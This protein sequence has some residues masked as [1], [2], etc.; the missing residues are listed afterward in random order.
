MK[1]NG[2]YEPNLFY[3]FLTKYHGSFNQ[4]SLTNYLLATVKTLGTNE[5]DE[6]HESLLILS[7]LSLWQIGTEPS[8]NQYLVVDIGLGA[9]PI[10]MI[11]N[12]GPH[13]TLVKQK[14]S[15]NLLSFIPIF[16]I[17]TFLLW[18]TLTYIFVWFFVQVGS[19]PRE[20]TFNPFGI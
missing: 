18:Q 9:V 10:M 16:S 2:F 12:C 19:S 13:H 11:G 6:F 4:P 15:R 1:R 20:E 3:S 5:V 7:L 14:P 17:L 8:D